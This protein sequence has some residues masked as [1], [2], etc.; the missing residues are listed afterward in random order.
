MDTLRADL[1]RASG[2]EG[3]EHQTLPGIVLLS[4][5]GDGLKVHETFGFQTLDPDSPPVSKDNTFWIASCTKLLTAIS[6]LQYVER[7]SVD[8]DEDIT[9]IIHEWKDLEVLEGFDDD[10]KPIVRKAKTKLTLRH[11]LTH[12]SGMCYQY[13]NPIMPKYQRAMGLPNT[14][15]NEFTLAERT[16]YPLLFEPGTGWEYSPSLDWAG[17]VVERLS[18]QRLQEY[19]SEH[20]FRPLGMNSTTF[21]IKDRKDIQDKLI[22]ILARETPA[23]QDV[24]AKPAKLVPPTAFRTDNS[25]VYDAG[26]GGIHLVPSDYVKVLQSIM[27]N[28]GILL[29]PE[30][31]DLLFAPQ[32]S[33]SVWRFYIDALKNKPN[34]GLRAG[35]STGLWLEAEGEEKV[36]FGTSVNWAFGGLVVTKNIPGRRKKGSLSWGGLP[37]LVWWMDRTSNVY[38]LYATQILPFGDLPSLE[39]SSRFERAVYKELDGK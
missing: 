28:D 22:G 17:V 18:S 34:E 12:T 32:L 8:L 36:D 30:T 33:P 38:G 20:I 1:R 4:G 19:M 31:V 27:K 23:N 39:M 37:N 9:R 26:G 5:N 10:G 6:A 21:R 29:K 3:P 11:L 15:G 25:F 13:M 24:K 14:S 16:H 2:E 35:F 7:G